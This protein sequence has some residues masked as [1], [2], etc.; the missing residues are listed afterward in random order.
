[1]A[2]H[3]ALTDERITLS[4]GVE[5][6]VTVGGAGEPVIFLHGFPESRRTWRHQIAD[7]LVDHFVAAPDQ[8]GYAHSSKPPRVEDYTQEALAADV[9]A[10][11]DALGLDTF[12]LVGHDFGGIVAWSTATL[13]PDRVGRLVVANAPHPVVWQ[14]TA[15]LDP[16]QRAASQYITVFQDP[17]TPDRIAESGFDTFFDTRLMAQ[18]DP[19]KVTP[20]DRAAAIAALSVPGA[21]RAMASWY[22][23][24]GIVVPPV[25]AEAEVP[26]WAA[27]PTTPLE[28]PTLVL[29]GMADRNL[30]PSQLEGI[31]DIV[32]DL[33]LVQL[34]DTGHFSPWE[35]P[36]EVTAAIRQFLQ[37]R[38]L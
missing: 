22:R 11:A 2:G 25:G 1:V 10:L 29:W 21:F 35:A 9:I 7:L 12:T 14:R 15:V 31:T 6:D 27:G 28:M 18:M 30:M 17:S 8:R 26:E 23:A 4:T 16:A 13:H 38:P 37:E 5:L 24:V 36:A 33:T 32:G 19:T 20:D 34:P 3:S